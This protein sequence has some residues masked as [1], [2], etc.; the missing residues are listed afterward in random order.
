MNATVYMDDVLIYT[1]S[2]ENDHWEAVQKILKKLDEAG[3]YLDIEKCDFLCKEVKY[4]GFIVQAAKSVSVD[5]AKV[6]VIHEW[7]APISVSGF[8]SFL[9]FANFNRCFIEGFSEIAE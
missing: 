1:D 6:K 4:L 3:L 7:K 2:D 9:G 8:R 5:P